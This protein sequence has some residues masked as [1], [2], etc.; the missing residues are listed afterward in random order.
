[1]R[2]TKRVVSGVVGIG[3]GGLSICAVGA[4]PARPATGPTTKPATSAPVAPVITPEQQAKIEAAV[5]DLS[6]D[7][8]KKRQAAQDALARLG[9]S[10][11]PT[12]KQ[13]SAKGDDEEVR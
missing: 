3:F 6:A 9:P 4:E 1:M 8:W 13:L 12:L 5:A 2:W 10:A 7:D 11:V